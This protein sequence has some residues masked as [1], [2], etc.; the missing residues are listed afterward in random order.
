MTFWWQLLFVT[1]WEFWM[2]AAVD[3]MGP[4]GRKAHEVMPM[5]WRVVCTLSAFNQVV[6][7]VVPAVRVLH[8]F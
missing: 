1:R 6:S 7:A 8:S 5:W 2:L 3:L 4:D